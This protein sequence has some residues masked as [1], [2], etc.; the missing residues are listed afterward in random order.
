MII[1]QEYT[2]AGSWRYQKVPKWRERQQD[3]WVLLPR[4]T[5]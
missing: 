3:C 5:F 1:G 2:E 4:K